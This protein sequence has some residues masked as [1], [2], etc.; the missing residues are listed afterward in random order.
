MNAN[1]F[2]TFHLFFFL[3]SSFVVGQQK[4]LKWF[5]DKDFQIMGKLSTS[6]TRTYQRFPQ[7]MQSK[8][9]K[10]VWRLSKNASGLY[11]D[12]YTSSSQIQ[13]IYQVEEVLSFMHMP[14][15]GVS[16]VDLYA[17]DSAGNWH[18]VRGNYNFGDF[19]SYTFKKID[20]IFNEKI[21]AYRLYLPLYNTLKGLKIGVSSSAVFNTINNTSNQNPIVV[22]GTSIA[23][24]ACATRAGMSWTNI[25]GRNLPHPIVNLGFS[26]N[27]RL[28]SEIIDLISEKKAALY[29]LDCMPNFTPGQNLGPEQAKKR[30]R[31]A[32]INIRKKQP[33]TPIL[34]VAHAGYSDGIIQSDRYEIYSLLNKASEE[35]FEQLKQE[36]VPALYFLKK[37]ALG[38][39]AASFVDGT[40]P[41][42][43]GMTEY[44]KAVIKKIDLIGLSQD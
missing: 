7:S 35:T 19:I 33:L 8:V 26:G 44:A 22:Y 2:F 37:E 34:I 6:D 23:Q 4:D 41:N 14:A 10:E 38:L 15:T 17:L 36:N 21:V 18:W 12:F 29:I 40:H 32:V 27:G 5:S 16:G 13:V 39:T 9:R 31:E 30:L 11:L 20:P 42:D 25:I 1:S 43:L 28:E 24:G 3:F